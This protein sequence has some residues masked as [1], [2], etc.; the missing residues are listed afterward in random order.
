MRPDDVSRTA[1]IE[2][3]LFLEVCM[4]R[5]DLDEHCESFVYDEKMARCSVYNTS[6]GV[7]SL[8]NGQKS[9][10][11]HLDQCTHSKFNISFIHNFKF[12]Y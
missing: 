8:V 6:V 2:D 7:M 3:V 10:A 12:I 5:C 9:V 1:Q 11:K 4:I